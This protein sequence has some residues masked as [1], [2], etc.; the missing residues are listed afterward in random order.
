MHHCIVQLITFPYVKTDC[1][2]L[3]PSTATSH[4]LLLPT[5]EDDGPQT[6]TTIQVALPV[7]HDLIA[8]G[9]EHPRQRFPLRHTLL[10]GQGR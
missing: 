4:L 8:A 3:A 6:S 2:K 9:H 7:E 10:G 5:G 1:P